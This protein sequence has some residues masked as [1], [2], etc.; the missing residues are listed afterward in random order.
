MKKLI[1]I[2]I[3]A[4]AVIAG[5]YWWQAQA[6][7]LAEE[8]PKTSGLPMKIAKYYWPG[9]YW[10][11]IA[12]QKGW[13]EEAGLN[14]ELIDTNPD[15]FASQQATAAGKI[16]SNDFYLFDMIKFNLTGANLVM[17]IN[18]DQSAGA[19]AIVS[20]SGIAS[21]K[22]LQGK[23]VGVSKGS[24]MEYMLYL[25]L[26]KVGK[27]L[28][29][30]DII[31]IVAENAPTEF[32]ENNLDAIITW[33]P[34]VSTIIKTHNARKIL[35]T[36][37]IPGAFPL[38]QVFKRQFINE[39]PGDV[40]AFVNVWHRTTEFIKQHPKEAFGII[41]KIYNKSP[42][43]VQAFAQVDKIMDL[44]DNR[45]AFSYAAGF[46]SLHGAARQIN[47]YM[48]EAGVT[49]KRL[50]STE[51]LNADFIRNVERE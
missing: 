50:D 51:F 39:R 8:G 36:S 30:I 4:A 23:R 6:P 49:D 40:Q 18:N 3:L 5:V 9:S 37:H 29:D 11:E 43:E 41:A 13:F 19:E 25:A 34:I 10:V 14:V 35:D 7:Q 20:K 46:E 33:E 26:N 28:N 47:D 32:I 16:D 48:I 31:G 21:I 38:G 42:G 45:T 15:Y 44:A 27:N 24:T 12:E 2:L 1:P 17:V 22:E